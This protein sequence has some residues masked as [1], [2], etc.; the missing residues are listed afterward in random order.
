[1]LWIAEIIRRALVPFLIGTGTLLGVLLIVLVGQR[2]MREAL[3]WRKTG[4]ERRYQPMV[5]RLL[6]DDAKAP[7]RGRLRQV[8]RRHRPIVARLLVEPL[9]VLT[10][11]PV[12]RVREAAHFLGLTP[13]W[14]QDLTA[15]RWWKRAGAAL[16]L[17]F[18]REPAAYDALV[19]L[20]DDPHEEVRAAAAEA[21]GRFGDVRAVPALLARLSEQSRHQRARIVDAVSMLGRDGAPDVLAH[22]RRF[23]AQLPLLGE[24]I[25]SVAGAAAVPDLL[26]WVSAP[27][28]AIRAA[29]MLALGTI[30]IDDRSF[31]YALRALGDTDDDVRA[32]AAR[33]LGRSG[34]TDAAAYLAVH[35]ED[36]WI[37]AAQSVRALSA[38]GASGTA[39]LERRSS[40]EGQPGDLARQMLWEQRARR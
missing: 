36:T 40:E 10:G 22:A 32:M 6:R 13:V 16:A 17:G 34:R 7:R 26:E 33:A 2:V 31:Y 25:A 30:G 38:L 18:V 39:A 14:I 20:L 8:P 3:W 11:A 5:D 28:P 27:F 24:L 1:M 21:L 9:R 19:G 37:V 12:G 35:L 29:A 15:R 4:L 23:P